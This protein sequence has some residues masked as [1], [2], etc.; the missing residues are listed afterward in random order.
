MSLSAVGRRSSAMTAA[1]LSWLTEASDF[2]HPALLR[3]A[4][5]RGEEV[6]GPAAAPTDKLPALEPAKSRNTIPLPTL[7]AHL[8]F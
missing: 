8:T 7:Y 3:T 5:N 2:V 4:A 6:A 1:V